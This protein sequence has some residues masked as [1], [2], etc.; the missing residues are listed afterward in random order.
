MMRRLDWGRFAGTWY[1]TERDRF[2]YFS[3]TGACNRKKFIHDSNQDKF[4]RMNGLEEN[5]SENIEAEVAGKHKGLD[6][7]L[8]PDYK[9]RFL[10]TNT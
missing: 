8:D 7:S 9:L 10:V 6:I 2:T 5:L 3:W 4:S 1:E